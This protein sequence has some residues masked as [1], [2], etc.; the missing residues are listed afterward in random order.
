ME[1]ASRVEKLSN[2]QGAFHALRPKLA[3]GIDLTFCW[4]SGIIFS[5]KIGWWY[6]SVSKS[7]YLDVN[8]KSSLIC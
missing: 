2:C 7:A 4:R 3:F 6:D 5:S 8:V 1:A